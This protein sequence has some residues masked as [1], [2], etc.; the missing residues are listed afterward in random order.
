MKKLLLFFTTI[1]LGLSLSSCLDGGSQ[2][3]TEP[4]FVYIDQYQMANYGK[5]L[6]RGLIYSENPV[7]QMLDSKNF[8]Y[9]TYSWQEENGFTP[10]GENSAYNVSIAGDIM[11]IEKSNLIQASPSE[12]APTDRFVRIDGVVYDPE[13]VAYDDNWLMQYS[14]SGTEDEKPSVQFYLRNNNI[15]ESGEIIIDM[16]LTKTGTPKEGS[17][18]RELVNYTSVDMSFLRGMYL[19]ETGKEIKIKFNFY[20]VGSDTP[21]TSEL[22]YSMKARS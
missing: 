18:A 11:K 14:Y 22:T 9:F 5:A 10:I 19:G 21:V 15:E 2:N 7:F 4:S 16:R 3:F 20:K 8:C 6:G 17:T 12:D 1:T 13:G